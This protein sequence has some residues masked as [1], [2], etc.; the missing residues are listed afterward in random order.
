[1]FKSVSRRRCSIP[2][3]AIYLCQGW[4]ILVAAR[5]L[6]HA[7]TL[8]GALW[9]AAGGAAY[10]L[11]VIFFALDRRRFFHAAWHIFAMAGSIAHYCAVLFYVVPRST[12]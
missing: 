5:P 11:G 4:F 6:V 2:S 3:A 12:A 7:I 10:S 9:L 1:V 8:H